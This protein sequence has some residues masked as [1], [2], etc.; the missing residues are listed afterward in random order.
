[1]KH[2]YDYFVAGMKVGTKM[3]LG[4]GLELVFGQI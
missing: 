3:K 4:T 1:M 2:D